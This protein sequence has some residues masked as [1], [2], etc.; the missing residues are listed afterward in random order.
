MG[1][2]FWGIYKWK[3][4]LF[5][6]HPAIPEGR[7]PEGMAGCLR[8]AKTRESENRN[9]KEDR[10]G[11]WKGKENKE[12][13]CNFIFILSIFDGKLFFFE[14]VSIFETNIEVWFFFRLIFKGISILKLELILYF[15]RITFFNAKLLFLGFVF[16]RYLYKLN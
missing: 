12:N 3:L 2:F 1:S 15:F 13:K 7:R 6:G 8:R 14:I 10:K 16:Y 4:K 9:S 11:N 5:W